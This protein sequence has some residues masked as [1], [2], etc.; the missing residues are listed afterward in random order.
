MNCCDKNKNNQDAQKNKANKKGIFSGIIYGLVP[1]IGCIGFIIFSVLGVTTATAIFKPLLLSRYFFHILILIS[2]IFATISAV[3]YFKKQG[4]ISLSKKDG[5]WE[6]EFAPK[7]IKRKW[8][9]LLTL[10]GTTIGINLIL[11]M[12]IFPIVANID[13]GTS[14][15]AAISNAFQKEGNI[16]IKEGENLLSIKVDIPCPGH[17][18]LITGELKKISGVGSVGYRFPNLFDISYEYEK[19]SKENI[20]ALDV[21]DTYKATVTNEQQENVA[22]QTIN[23]PRE[24]QS[25]AGNCAIDCAGSSKGCGCGCRR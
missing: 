14:F 17:A 2:F 5:S 3:F 8:K 16:K 6:F 18:S 24:N 25:L 13:A 19:T 12:L 1:H 10:Y 23:N 22:E 11:F 15:T 9:Y 21:F 4:F 20:L 7:G